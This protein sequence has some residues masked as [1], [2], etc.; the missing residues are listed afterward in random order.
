MPKVTIRTRASSTTSRS[1]GS[2]RKIVFT[3]FLGRARS[4]KAFLTK[5]EIPWRSNL[6][7]EV[8]LRNSG[9][10]WEAAKRALVLEYGLTISVLTLWI[11]EGLTQA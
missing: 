6:F 11:S 5:R 1:P 3:R 4:G 7:A 8:C 10:I 2:E 9:P